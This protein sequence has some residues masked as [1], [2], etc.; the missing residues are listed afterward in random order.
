MILTVLPQIGTLNASRYTAR[1]AMLLAHYAMRGA[2]LEKAQMDARWD[3]VRELQSAEGEH[4][5]GIT[6]RLEDDLTAA[7][8]SAAQSGEGDDGVPAGPWHCAAP[9]E[10]KHKSAAMLSAQ[11][12]QAYPPLSAP[13]AAFTW[14]KATV[15]V[16]CCVMCYVLTVAI[17]ADGVVS[18]VQALSDARGVTDLLVDAGGYRSRALHVSKTAPPNTVIRR[19]VASAPGDDSGDDS[20]ADDGSGAEV[21][22]ADVAALVAAPSSVA[23]LAQRCHL[24]RQHCA[25]SVGA[26]ATVCAAV[27]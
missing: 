1:Q 11:A 21:T 7:I 22:E 15:S 19:S 6:S 5:A 26:H 23:V 2:G 13:A 17:A 12:R 14:N 4:N 16:R 20:V 3:G 9:H 8:Q 27:Q 18:R 25:S 24:A 10:C